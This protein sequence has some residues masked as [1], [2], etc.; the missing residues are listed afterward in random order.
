MLP[1]APTPADLW[2]RHSIRATTGEVFALAKLAG[3]QEDLVVTE[4][5][6]KRA[7]GEAEMLAAAGD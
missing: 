4:V 7:A 6:A 2:S 3:E 5:M 1:L